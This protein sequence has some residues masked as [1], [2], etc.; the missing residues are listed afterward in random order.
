MQQ[1]LGRRQ[2]HIWF[3]DHTG[4]FCERPDSRLEDDIYL[5]WSPGHRQELYVG[6]TKS[7]S[8]TTHGPCHLDA[9]IALNTGLGKTLSG[10]ASIPTRWYWT[11]TSASSDLIA[12]ITYDLW[13]STTSTGSST[14]EIMIWLS[15]RGGA[16]PAG[17]Q[18][19]TATVSTYL[20]SLG[21]H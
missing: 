13:L 15:T 7:Y 10:I 12:D 19:T 20:A 8:I 9:N 5:G 2:R 14:D 18:I 11:Y 1:P 3:A 21:C 4:Y 17:S 16:G 6:R